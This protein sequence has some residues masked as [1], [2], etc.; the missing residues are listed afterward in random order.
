MINWNYRKINFWKHT[1]AYLTSQNPFTFQFIFELSGDAE[2][3]SEKSVMKV[4]CARG[5]IQQ[6]C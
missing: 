4:P 5:P 6:L 2:A 3:P 1:E